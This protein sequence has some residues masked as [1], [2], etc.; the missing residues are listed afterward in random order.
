[1]FTRSY[2]PKDILINLSIDKGCV[3]KVLLCLGSIS[4]VYHELRAEK[5][6]KTSIAA[7]WLDIANAYDSMPHQSIY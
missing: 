3:V 7:I 6:N 1:M 5:L 4:L 2:H